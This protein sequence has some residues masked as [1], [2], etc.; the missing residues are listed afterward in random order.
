MAGK[1]VLKKQVH[2]LQESVTRLL[3]TQADNEITLA[4]LKELLVEK[5]VVE[6]DE[7]LKLI[8]DEIEKFNEA[9]NPAKQKSNIIVP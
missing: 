2:A 8:N 7:L 3:M 5:G 4:V 9:L 6:K 1:D